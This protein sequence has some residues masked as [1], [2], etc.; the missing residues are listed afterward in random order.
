MIIFFGTRTG[1]T[2]TVA[3]KKATCPYCNQ[4]GYLQASRT[5]NFIHLFWI[6]V[7][8]LGIHIEAICEY[9]KKGFYKGEFTPEM[10][11]EFEET[12]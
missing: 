5:P 10:L 8:R 6:P 12:K 9:C 1:K 4:K 3:L 2:K 7:Y 11:Q